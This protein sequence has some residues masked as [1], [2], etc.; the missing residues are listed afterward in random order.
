MSIG[1]VEMGSQISQMLFR[2]PWMPFHEE[3]NMENLHAI[4]SGVQLYLHLIVRLKS[5]SEGEKCGI[6]SQSSS[7]DAEENSTRK[8][9]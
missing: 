9:C 3:N 4:A 5:V 2:P 6:D 8:F 1:L 7:Y